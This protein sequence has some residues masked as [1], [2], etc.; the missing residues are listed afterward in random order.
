MC[1]KGFKTPRLSY[2]SVKNSAPGCQ[3]LKTM[4]VQRTPCFFL[5]IPRLH[6]ASFPLF[7]PLILPLSLKKL[8]LSVILDISRRRKE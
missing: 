8:N 5:C 3:A 1:H 7:S 4:N 6:F 2:F